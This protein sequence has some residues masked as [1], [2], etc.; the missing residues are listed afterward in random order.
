MGRGMK[1]GKIFGIDLQLDWS[2]I[3]IFT[4]LVYQLGSGVFPAWHPTWSAGLCWGVAI[5]A[6]LV[7][8]ASIVAHEL[9][10]SLVGR[11]N[12][13]GVRS[14][15]LFIF[16]GVASI[17]NEPPSPKAEWRMAIAGPIASLMIG[18]GFLA[19]GGWLASDAALLAEG[20]PT[21]FLE[22]LGPVATVLAWVGPVNLML[23]VFNL[24]PGFPLDGGRVLRALLWH[25]KGDLVEATRWAAMSGRVIA[26]LMIAG[27]VAAAL[28]VP[29]PGL[30]AGVGQGLWMIFIG[31]F[32]SNAAR[33]GYRQVV[34]EQLLAGVSVARIMQRRPPTIGA[35][36]PVGVLVDA[37]LLGSDARA[38][39]VVDDGGGLLGMVCIDDVRKTPRGSWLTTQVG[40]IM[41]GRE[42]LELATPT[43]P[44]V[45]ALR[46]MV[47]RDVG[48]LP[49]VDSG[50]VVGLL[51][52]QD[53]VRWLQL[54]AESTAV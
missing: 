50:V 10:H 49:V 38:F 21:A 8:F 28:G 6:A 45:D 53:V 24:V 31:F 43:T 30:S 26:W 18:V 13:I 17:E 15:T 34:T 54:H 25:L 20:E 3:V 51:R 32:L 35:D 52:R 46:R 37:H 9:A 4:L 5:A 44:A 29:P 40:T 27:G 19:L 11:R 39:P 16:G 2:V 42:E 14:I 12:G 36:L 23:A 48:Q 47:G 1:L 22:A 33:E 41:T 7:F